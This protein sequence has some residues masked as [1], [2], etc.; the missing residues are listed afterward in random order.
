[1]LLFID[2]DYLTTLFNKTN[3]NTL[4]N[5]LLTTRDNQLRSHFSMGY[6]T[7]NILPVESTSLG[8]SNL[9][10]V[11]YPCILITQLNICNIVTLFC[12]YYFVF[13]LVYILCL[14]V[15]CALCFL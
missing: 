14:T 3:K 4:S 9:V 10:S 12:W 2:T 13:T 7:D 5:T 6:S 11:E 15:K 1:M 8:Q